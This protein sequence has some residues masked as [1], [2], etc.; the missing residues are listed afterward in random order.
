MQNARIKHASPEPSPEPYSLQNPAAEP[1]VRVLGGL[2][3]RAMWQGE[4][5]NLQAL[6]RAV[7]ANID[8]RKEGVCDPYLDMGT[9]EGVGV[10]LGIRHAF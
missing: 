1:V 4:G 9:E 7:A 8:C 5:L 2:P 6:A 3:F 10:K